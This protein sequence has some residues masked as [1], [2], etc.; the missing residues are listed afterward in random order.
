MEGAWRGDPLLRSLLKAE[1]T[2][3]DLEGGKQGGC[4]LGVETEEGR[5][6]QGKCFVGGRRGESADMKQ[7]TFQREGTGWTAV[8]GRRRRA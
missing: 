3:Q 5:G 1:S 6:L 4:L 7:G 8:W 2:R